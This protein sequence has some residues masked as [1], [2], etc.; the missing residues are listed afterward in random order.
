MNLLVQPPWEVLEVVVL[1]KQHPVRPL[2]LEVPRPSA[3]LKQDPL[4]LPHWQNP[5]FQASR[6]GS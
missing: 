6:E 3:R 1:L 5:Q 4:C 2:A